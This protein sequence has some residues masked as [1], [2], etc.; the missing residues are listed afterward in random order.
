M[1]TQIQIFQNLSSSVVIEEASKLV[2][3]VFTRT[4][5]IPHGPTMNWQQADAHPV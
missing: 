1:V 5:Q 4:T 3:P 2:L